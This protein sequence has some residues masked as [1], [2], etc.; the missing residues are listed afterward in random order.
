MSTIAHEPASADRRRP[1]FDLHD[2]LRKARELTGMEKQEFAEQLGIHRDSVANYEAGRRHPRRPVLIAWALTCDVD[3]DWLT[4]GVVHP[5]GLEPR[6]HW[7]RADED[8]VIPIEW[9]FEL[10]ESR[11]DREVATA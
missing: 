3:L 8:V 4:D 11:Q 7:L 9:A 6:T 1:S 5:L 2:R 10:R